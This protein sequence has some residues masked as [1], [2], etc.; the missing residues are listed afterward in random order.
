METAAG[1]LVGDGVEY[2]LKPGANT[3]GRKSDNDVAIVDAYV[4]GRHGLIELAED[5]IFLTDTGSTNGTLLNDAKLTPNMRTGITPEDTIRLGSL[6]FQV[7]LES[8]PE[9]A[10]G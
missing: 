4:S 10:D 8:A 2:P 1:H 3:F 9:P 7:R 5:G 6:T